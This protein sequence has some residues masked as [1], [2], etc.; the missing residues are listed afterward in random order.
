VT[1]PGCLDPATC[2]VPDPG[3][4]DLR[5]LRL[6]RLPEAA[7]VHTS[8]RRDRWPEL[9][10]PPVIGNAR[11]SPL[12]VEGSAIPTMYAAR[13][14]TVALL[15][16][17]F[18]EVHHIGTRIISERLRLATR[19]LVALT[20]PEP[21]PLIDLTD[22]GLH[23]VGLARAQLVA[24][25]PEH[26][27][28]TREWAATLHHRRVG[29]IASVGLLWCSRVAELAGADSLLFGDLLPRASDV[30]VLFGDRVSTEPAVWQPGDPHYGDLSAGDGRLLAEQIADQL[31][32]VI[33]PN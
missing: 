16:T 31:G 20:V 7:T 4:V 21:M 25:T 1:A 23:R 28:C 12:L 15:E 17:A 27:P 29:G 22:E 24:T 6:I 9:F 18:H 5:R 19:G 33:V 30:C 2:P 8:Y 10:N 14:Q 32:A 3:D 13:T 11:F 26:Y